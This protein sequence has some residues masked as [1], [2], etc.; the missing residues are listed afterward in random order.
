MIS[1]T[2]PDGNEKPIAFASHTL[3]SAE[4]NY[5]QIEK[6]ALALVFGV[7]KFHQY[8]Y[9]RKFTMVTDHKPLMAILGPKKGIPSLAAARLQRWAILLSAYNYNIEFH[10]TATHGNADALSRLPLPYT[11]L[12]EP[13]STVNY[14]P[15]FRMETLPVTATEIQVETRRDPVLSRV[16]TYVQSGWPAAVPTD[17]KPFKSREMELGLECGCLMLGSRVVV[18]T[19]LQAQSLIPSTRT[20]PASLV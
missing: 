2:L 10:P 15:I 3:T 17:L 14:L 8:L 7:H 19:K 6:E 5:P 12:L 9:G 4:K 20:T 16:V 13:G 1:H 18:P 11:E